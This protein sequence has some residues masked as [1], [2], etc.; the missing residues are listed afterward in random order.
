VAIDGAMVGNGALTGTL[1]QPRV[2]LT[3]GFDKVDAGP[4]KLTQ[5]QLILSFRKGLDAS[6]GRV[7]ITS[8]SNYGPPPPRAASSW[9]ARRSA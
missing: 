8:A 7:T 4:L 3:A 2:D 6:D 5:T 1:A 9:A